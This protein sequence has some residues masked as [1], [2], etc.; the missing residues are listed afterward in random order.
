MIYLTLYA[1][2]VQ[3]TL[4]AVHFAGCV[5]YFLA[6]HYHDPGN[7][8]IGISDGG[9]LEKSLW[10]KYI[11]SIYWSIT[12]LTTTGYGDLHAVNTREKIFG[13][14]YMLFNLGLTAYL[15]GNMTNLVVH[16]TSRTRKF[17]SNSD[18][19]MLRLALLMELSSIFWLQ[20]ILCSIIL[21]GFEDSCAKYLFSPESGDFFSMQFMQEEITFCICSSWKI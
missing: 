7:T 13:T 4:F 9:F 18:L 14:L 20:H 15:I 19:L 8:W 11:T 10:F 2:S 5:N 6:A 12:T 17:V 21:S 1:M 3:V 16:G